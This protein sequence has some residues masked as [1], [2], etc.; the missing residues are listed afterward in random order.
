MKDSVFISHKRMQGGKVV[1]EDRAS[2]Y[3]HEEADHSESL[4]EKKHEGKHFHHASHSSTIMQVSQASALPN[5]MQAQPPQGQ[6][7]REAVQ[8]P[9]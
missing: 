2:S 5:L 1:A 8:L 4:P 7:I 3:Y 6:T 9:L